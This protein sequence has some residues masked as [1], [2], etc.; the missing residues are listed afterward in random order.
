MKKISLILLA[1]AVCISPVFAKTNSDYTNDVELIC[2]LGIMRGYEDGEFRP[3]GYLT[4]SE[5]VVTVSA[6][7][8]VLPDFS[9]N[10]FT[11]VA[12]SHW[13]KAYIEAAAGAGIVSGVA[14]GV[15]EPDKK[16]TKYQV[17]VMLLN[18]MGYSVVVKPDEN[19]IKNYT[20]LIAEKGLYSGISESADEPLTRGGF[21]RM[22]SNALEEPLL[23]TGISGGY[24]S[25]AVDGT[26][27]LLSEYLGVYIAEGQITANGITGLT[28]GST[29]PDSYVRIGTDIYDVGSTDIA[30]Y[31]GR[32]VKV[33]YYEPVKDEKTV[34]YYI[35]SQRESILVNSED[36]VSYNAG[37]FTYY[38]SNGGKQYAKSVNVLPVADVIFNGVYKIPSD[39]DFM[40]AIS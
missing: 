36:I 32:F 9:K 27:T 12:E 23:N 4:R 30:D 14:P 28:G 6:L 8:G 16:V 20:G 2:A 29:V 13:A 21:A 7:A 1:M 10:T 17:A 19:G 33:Y 26:N 18:T 5:A 37:V 24:P 25:Y 22:I 15:F 34:A 39:I 40:P 3:D 31:I 11:D 38:N 35:L